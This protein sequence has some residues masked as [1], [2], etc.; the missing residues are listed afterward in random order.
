MPNSTPAKMTR[1][2]L[3][4]SHKSKTAS[5]VS[6]IQA[7]ARGT[8]TPGSHLFMLLRLC[9]SISAGNLGSDAEIEGREGSI[10]NSAAHL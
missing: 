7:R 8:L 1:S 5:P 10:I 9:T 3:I 2:T 4:V 6:T